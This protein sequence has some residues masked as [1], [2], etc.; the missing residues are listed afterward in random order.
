MTQT[1]KYSNVLITLH[2]FIAIL[3]LAAL[4]MGTFVLQETPNTSEEKLFGL[5]AHMT[6]GMVILITM[7]VRFLVR[8]FTQKPPH[9]QTGNA[10]LD[11]LGIIVHYLLYLAV[12]VMAISGIGIS[13]M[14]GLPE[15]LFE[16]V[17]TL[18]AS[19]DEFPPRLAHGIIASILTGLIV[20]HV[21]GWAY[22]QFILKDKLFSRIWFGR[23]K[24]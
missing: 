15:I 21:A 9:A 22:H 6:A 13:I 8:L 2:W 17:G 4:V 5:K 14:A 20:L 10:L 19:F 3:L 16:G 24:S 7:V 1:T 11:K 23:Q 18:P 12:I